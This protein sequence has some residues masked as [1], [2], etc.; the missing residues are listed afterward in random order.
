[1]TFVSLHL[2]VL[3]I[4]ILLM[5]SYIMPLLARWKKTFCVPLAATSLTTSLIFSVLLAIKLLAE[6]PFDYKLGGWSPPWGIEF[7]VDYLAVFTMLTLTGISL[8]IF[9][10]TTKALTY[11]VKE[12]VT[13]WYY[14][15]YLLLMASLLGIVLTNDLFNL[16]VFTEICTIAACAIISIKEKRDCIEAS[17]KYLILSTVGSGTLLMGIALIYMITGHL[18]FDYVAAELVVVMHVYP[19]NILAAMALFMVAISVKAALFP[20]YVWLPDAYSAAASP[21]TALLASLVGKVYAVMFIELF[22]TVFPREIF[23]IV[24]VM[25]IFLFMASGGIIMGS[26]FAV[27]QKDIKRMLAY[28]SVAQI[29]YVF[30]GISLL[31][32]EGIVG[33]ILHIFNHALIKSM[34]FLAV[35]AIIYATGIRRIDELK[36]IG[37]KMP[38]VMAVFA[39]GAVAMI[40]IPLTNGFISKWYLAIGAIHAGH[41]F[42]IVVILLSSLLNGVY[43]L[44]IVVGAFFGKR[45][46]PLPVIKK[47]PWQMT[48]PLIVLGG[49]IIFTGIFPG[50]ILELVK[51]SVVILLN[52]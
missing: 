13:G 38:I 32:F 9:M 8:L 14:T 48:L 39:I 25:D 3:S 27:V 40:G 43:F 24:P 1:M 19:R 11:E 30:L 15:L 34:L 16:F 51:R 36:G 35:G 37:L 4:V 29:G 6:G 17:L 28:S 46:K 50:V 10:Y 47:L 31:S 5:C 22:L 2:P 21:A 42:Y 7:Q 18:N 49:G 12:S 33:G 44:P 52:I 45:E 41:P 20:L 26:L 23:D